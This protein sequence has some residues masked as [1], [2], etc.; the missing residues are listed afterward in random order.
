MGSKPGDLVPVQNVTTAVNSVVNS[1]TLHPGDVLMMTSLTY[2]AVRAWLLVHRH[3]T[4]CST[5]HVTKSPWYH[6][7][8]HASSSA[9]RF[10]VRSQ[11]LPQR[12]VPAC[13]KCSWT[14]AVPATPTSSSSA[15]VGR[16][17]PRGGACGWSSLTTSP[18]SPQ[19][20]LM[21]S[22]WLRSATNMVP[23][24]AQGIDRQHQQKRPHHTLSFPS[25]ALLV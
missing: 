8:T 2:P 15:F 10:A 23:W 7:T 21:S 16:Y 5:K 9:C 6:H 12:P 25:P 17:G 13:W 18:R 11:Q 3:P 19:C 14:P 4:E 24:C 20:S 22:G 1:L